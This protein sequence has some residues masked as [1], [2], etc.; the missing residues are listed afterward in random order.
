M[1]SCFCDVE[2]QWEK[3]SQSSVVGRGHIGHDMGSYEGFTQY[4][5]NH[6]RPFLFG[7]HI[8]FCYFF[9]LEMVRGH[10]FWTH[11][12][13]CVARFD[14]LPLILENGTVSDEMGS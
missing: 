11:L 14:P 13:M 4:V 10:D 6:I 12:K 3:V 7:C 2:S 8:S 1:S 9:A 5:P